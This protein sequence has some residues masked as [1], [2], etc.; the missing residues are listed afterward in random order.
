MYHG[1]CIGSFEAT[2]S[3]CYNMKNISMQLFKKLFLL[4]PR[5]MSA[6]IKDNLKGRA[7]A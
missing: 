1:F 2:G 5:M 7:G 3:C 6:I 4:E